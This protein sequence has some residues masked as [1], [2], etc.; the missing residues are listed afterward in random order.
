MEEMKTVMVSRK[1]CVSKLRQKRE[2][3]K[4]AIR[5]VLHVPHAL[6]HIVMLLHIPQINTEIDLSKCGKFNWTKD[7]NQMYCCNWIP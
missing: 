5:D 4:K 7:V 3:V 6:F 1:A 2:A